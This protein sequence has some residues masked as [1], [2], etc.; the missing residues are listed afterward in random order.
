VVQ[1]N[2]PESEKE[3]RQEEEKYRLLQIERVQIK[4]GEG[5]D[6]G[7]KAKYRGVML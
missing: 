2:H 1:R 5:Y 3:A 7:G 6:V 4:E